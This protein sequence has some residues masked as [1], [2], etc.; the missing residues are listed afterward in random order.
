MQLNGVAVF[1]TGGG[2]GLGAATA[3]AMAAKGAK[4]TVLDQSKGKCGNSGGRVEGGR[5]RG[6]RHQ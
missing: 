4:I 6:R 5:D 1:I 3:R 2:S